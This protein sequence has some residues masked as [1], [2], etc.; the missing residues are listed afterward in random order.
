M[1]K[2]LLSLFVCSFVSLAAYDY[3]IHDLGVSI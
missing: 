2:L 1:K 3:E